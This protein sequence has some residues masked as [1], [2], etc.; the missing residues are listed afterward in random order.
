MEIGVLEDDDWSIWIAFDVIANVA[1]VL[2][3]FNNRIKIV[4]IKISSVI[5]AVNYEIGGD[6]DKGNKQNADDDARFRESFEIFH[7]TPLCYND[8]IMWFKVLQ[9]IV[10]VIDPK[11]ERY[12]IHKDEPKPK[13]T[14]KTLEEFIGV[15]RRTPRNV[16]DKK[17]RARIAAIM[18][19]DERKVGDLMVSKQDMVFVNKKEMLGPLVL[20]RLYKSGFTNFPVVDD[21]GKVRGIINTEALNNLEIRKLEKAEKYVDTKVNYLHATDGLRFAVERIERTNGYY[22]LVLDENE[23]LAGFFTVEM[24]LDYLSL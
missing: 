24:L 21:T 16:L 22:F 6:A 20:D 3:C 23:K 4:T 19:Y 5:V 10:R 13:Y 7:I 2:I 12:R 15:L 1:I 14:P 11:L 9:K 8:Y 17:D 18:S